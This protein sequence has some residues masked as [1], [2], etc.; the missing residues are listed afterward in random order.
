MNEE[1]LKVVCFKWKYTGGYKLPSL[2]VVGEYTS[3]YVNRLYHSVER[4]LTIP[5]EFICVTDDPQGIECKTIPM[6]D[7]HR[8]LGGCYTRLKLFSLEM[9]DLIGN[10]F[11]ALDL[12]TVIVG[13]LD[14]MFNRKGDFVINKYTTHS[15][16]HK[17]K[18]NQYYN[19]SIIMMD[20]GARQHVWKMFDPK[21]S[22]LL[23]QK[24]KGLIGTDQAWIS[25]LLGNSEK[26]FAERDGVYRFQLL[27]DKKKL[28]K[29]AKLILF[30]G[31]EDPSKR[32]EIDWV[33]K[34]WV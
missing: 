16:L 5:H 12:D 19:G 9:K 22:P 28:P 4:N 31:K 6:W 14:K 25:L 29:N 3:K 18:N 23:I 33:K 10:R 27:A 2:K 8:K 32:K 34:N 24:N 1:T 11:I 26:M 7:D 20:A 13:N 17:H 15:H 30:A 21:T